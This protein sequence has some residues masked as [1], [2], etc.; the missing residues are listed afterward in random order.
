MLLSY[1]EKTEEKRENRMQKYLE[2]LIKAWTI[3]N[4][5]RKSLSGTPVFMIAIAGFLQAFVCWLIAEFFSYFFSSKIE[6]AGKTVAI[7]MSFG[8][9][10]VSALTIVGFASWINRG[11]NLGGLSWFGGFLEK[12]QERYYEPTNIS[13]H[14]NSLL[15]NGIIICQVLCVAALMHEG[16][17]FWILYA[18]SLSY[19]TFAAGI[20]HG[21]EGDN[22]N[23]SI[24]AFTAGGVLLILSCVFHQHL[25]PV[26]IALIGSFFL[27]KFTMKLYISKFQSTNEELVRSTGEFMLSLLLIAGL[28]LIK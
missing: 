10:L 22:I 9:A 16:H 25:V 19:C 5:R 28:L 12:W 2:L 11:K 13:K 23:S 18:Y 21:E 27:Y 17:T 7:G 3:L 26:V 15:I 8:V 24:E 4:G 6:V 20:A 14:Y 1:P